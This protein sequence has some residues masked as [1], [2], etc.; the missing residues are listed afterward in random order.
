MPYR[1]SENY[2][3]GSFPSSAVAALGEIKSVR[4]LPISIDFAMSLDF[5]MYEEWPSMYFVT[6]T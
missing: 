2:Y 5:Q 1:K 3:D 6:S 4:S